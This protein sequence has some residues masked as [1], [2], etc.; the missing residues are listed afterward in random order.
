MG[1]K[2]SDVVRFDLGLFLQGQTRTT[3]HKKVL[4]TCLLLVLEVYNVKQ[5]NGKSWAGNLLI[6]SYLTLDLSCKVKRGQPN[7]KVLITR[8]FLVLEVCNVKTNLTGNHELGIFGPF[9]QGQTMVHW[10]W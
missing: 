3:K 10:L 7:I 9:F 2:S 6:W 5:T 1:W 4:I 8:L